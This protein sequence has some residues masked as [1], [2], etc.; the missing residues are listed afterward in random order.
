MTKRPRRNH[1]AAFTAWN[2]KSKPTP[3]APMGNKSLALT[4]GAPSIKRPIL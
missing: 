4:D 1:T 2:F 3:V